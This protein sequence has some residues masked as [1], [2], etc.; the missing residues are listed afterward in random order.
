MQTTNISWATYSWNPVTGCSHAGP[1]CWN[2]YAE[3]LHQQWAAR[4]NPPAYVSGEEWTPQ[5]AAENVVMHP[6]RL[7]EPA[8]YGFPEGPGRVF[9]GSMTDMFHDEVDPGFVQRALDVCRRHPEQVWIWLTKRPQNAAEWRLDWPEN[10]WLGTSCGSGSGG[11][12]PATTHRIEQLRDVDVAT[13]WV[14]AEPLIEPLGSVALDHIDWLVV[15]GESGGADVR[16]EM[17][18]E[19]ARDLLRQAREQDV[20]FYFKQDSGPFQDSSTALTVEKEYGD[21]L[22]YQQREIREF[23]PLP[24]VT[25]AAREGGI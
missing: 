8:A 22:T 14:S 23:P 21:L 5:N 24:D 2:C 25:T 12:L 18:H 13:K 16:R 1:E 9:V 4:E 10:C 17:E 19:W 20:A 3:T 11:E 15:G 6:D 7:D